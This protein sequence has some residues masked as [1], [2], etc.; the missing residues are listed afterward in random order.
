MRSCA[1][2]C[3]SQASPTF[4]QLPELLLLLGDLVQEEL[5]VEV[6]NFGWGQAATCT[7]LGPVGATGREERCEEQVVHSGEGQTDPSPTPSWGQ[8]P[9]LGQQC[10]ELQGAGLSDGQALPCPDLLRTSHAR[11]HSH[12]PVSPCMATP[13]HLSSL[14]AG[15]NPLPSLCPRRAGLS[16]V[17]QA[18]CSHPS[19]GAGSQLC[20]S[21]SAPLCYPQST[22]YTSFHGCRREVFILTDRAK[23]RHTAHL[24]HALLLLQTLG[25]CC[26]CHS[27]SCPPACLPHHTYLSIKIFTDLVF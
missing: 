10:S 12:S 13:A 27:P 19:W 6:A 4:Q 23:P 9:S 26:P 25:C 18:I 2:P 7:V 8:T 21:T 17:P 16:P 22:G 15:F 14:S 24:S 11:V 1:P 20:S 3:T 5:G